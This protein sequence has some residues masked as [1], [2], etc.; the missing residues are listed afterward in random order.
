MSGNLHGTVHGEIL[1]MSGSLSMAG[2]GF[3]NSV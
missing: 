2:L 1:D 3:E